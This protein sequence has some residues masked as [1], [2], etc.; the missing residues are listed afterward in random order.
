VQVP[1]GLCQLQSP[2]PHDP[3][4]GAPRALQI[5]AVAK[6]Q[7]HRAKVALDAHG[8][9]PHDARVIDQRKVDGLPVEG[10]HGALRAEAQRL[11]HARD[12]QLLDGDL[13]PTQRSAADHP[14]R[15]LAQRLAK[16]EVVSGYQ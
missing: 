10:A 12:V 3:Q 8:Q 9:Q 15:A 7:H 4:R 11:L 16:R 5:A 13:L 14:E 6:L 2:L 1:Q